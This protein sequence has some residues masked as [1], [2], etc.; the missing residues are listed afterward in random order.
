MI[1]LLAHGLASPLGPADIAHHAFAAGLSR[2]ERLDHAPVL[3]RGDD[4]GRAVGHAVLDGDAPHDRRCRHLLDLARTELGPHTADAVL[5][6]RPLPDP[7]RWGP[8]GPPDLPADEVFA[9]GHAAAAAALVRAEQ[10]ITT[11]ICRRVLVAAVDS[12]VDPM[13]LDWLAAEDRLR[14]PETPDGLAPGEAAVCWLLGPADPAGLTQV[15]AGFGP[16]TT[17]RSA[18]ADARRWHAAAGDIPSGRDWV[19]LNG[20]PRRNRTWGALAHLLHRQ[21]AVTASDGWGDLGAAS[22]LA[23]GSLA[24]AGGDRPAALWSVSDDGAVGVIALR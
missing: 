2:G 16:A 3:G 21:D 9:L 22:A 11:G 18:N 20:E 24:V 12:L 19:D 13:S 8:D 4:A 5:L 14:G 23:A 17:A 7:L 15:T 1:A 10:L 6:C